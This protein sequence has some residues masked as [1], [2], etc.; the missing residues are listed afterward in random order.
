[1]VAV[2]VAVGGMALLVLPAAT[3]AEGGVTLPG[4]VFGL[5][6][7]LPGH[8]GLAHPHDLPMHDQFG[9]I[10]RSVAEPATC[11]T[12]SPVHSRC[13]GGSI[14]T[15]R[16]SACNWHRRPLAHPAAE[17]EF[18]DWHARRGV[19]AIAWTAARITCAAPVRSVSEPAGTRHRES[20]AGIPGRLSAR[21]W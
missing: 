5:L 9:L 8:R 10:H 2:V 3:A 16:R 21:R 14:G 18:G 6:A 7:A 17:P 13:L 15:P 4:V 20:L 19:Q 11:A 12:A 1:M